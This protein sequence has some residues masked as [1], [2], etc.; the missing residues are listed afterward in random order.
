MKL[1]LRI[2]ERFQGRRSEVQIADAAGRIVMTV[3][4]CPEAEKVARAI[5]RK[6]NRWRFLCGTIEYTRDDWEWERNVSA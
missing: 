1:P 4:D 6:F 2:V 3:N 5:V